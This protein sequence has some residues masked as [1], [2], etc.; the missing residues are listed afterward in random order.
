[1]QFIYDIVFSLSM[2]Q[3]IDDIKNLPGLLDSYSWL[4]FI[5]NMQWSVIIFRKINPSYFRTISSN[6]QTSPFTCFSMQVSTRQLLLDESLW[7]GKTLLFRW[8][9]MRPINSSTLTGTNGFK[10]PEIRMSCFSITGMQLKPFS[11][12]QICFCHVT[13]RF[14]IQ[15]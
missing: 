4:R 14:F 9:V 11:F 10:R 2:C 5:W 13:C 1:M 3:M 8:A 15:A 12:S 6:K 7:G